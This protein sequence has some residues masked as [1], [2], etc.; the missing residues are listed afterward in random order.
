MTTSKPSKRKI[1]R[2]LAL[3]LLFIASTAISFTQVRNSMENGIT[4]PKEEF[5]APINEA[6]L[7]V[8]DWMKSPFKINHESVIEIECWMTRPFTISS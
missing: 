8:E 1:R 4:D 7:E 3:A 6:R 2:I 5:N